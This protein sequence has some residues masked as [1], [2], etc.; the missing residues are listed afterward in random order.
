MNIENVKSEFTKFVQQ[1]D[2]EYPKMKRKLGRL[3]KI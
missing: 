3:L 1:Y 2:L